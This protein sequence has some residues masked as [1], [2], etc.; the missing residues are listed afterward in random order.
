MN[1]MQV[2]VINIV[3]N[4]LTAKSNND[5]KVEQGFHFDL[6]KLTYENNINNQNAFC[7]AVKWLMD[8]EGY[9]VAQ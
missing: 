2:E 7:G 8:N 3:R 6:M 5:N 9:T 4:M 1:T